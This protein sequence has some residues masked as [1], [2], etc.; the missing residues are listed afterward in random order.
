M[1]IEIMS[2]TLKNKRN[3]MFLWSQTKWVEAMVTGLEISNGCYGAIYHLLTWA[4]L[5]GLHWHPLTKIADGI[6]AQHASQRRKHHLW[7]FSGYS[8]FCLIKPHLASASLI[9][10]GGKVVKMHFGKRKY[11]RHT[12]RLLVLSMLA[13]IGKEFVIGST[14]SRDTLLSVNYKTDSSKFN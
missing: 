4:S 9:C 1:L 5:L 14:I 2:N 10:K 3:R 12:M 11:F 13:E 8:I 7:K 6:A